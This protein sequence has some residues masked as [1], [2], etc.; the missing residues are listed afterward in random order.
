MTMK[1]DRYSD[2]V[3]AYTV[4]GNVFRPQQDRI[5]RFHWL[6]TES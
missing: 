6:F 2:Y 4:Y 5:L 3:F 1:A